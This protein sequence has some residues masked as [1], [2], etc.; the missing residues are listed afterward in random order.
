ML[1]R[2]YHV[3]LSRECTVTSQSAG[4]QGWGVVGVPSN[5]STKPLPIGVGV[6]VGDAGGVGVT[7]GSGWAGMLSRA[8]HVSLS[9]ECTVT[10]QSA[11]RQGWGVVG[12]PSNRSTKP[13]PIG[14]GVGVGDAV[15]VGVTVGAGVAV[16]AST[17]Q[18]T[19]FGG[20][21]A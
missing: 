19:R 2:A 14:V 13:L 20:R 15:G 3:S 1:S 6:A 18:I 5:R 12:V 4:R 17:G 21:I 10:S 7:V 11:G 8:Y 16:G 9:R